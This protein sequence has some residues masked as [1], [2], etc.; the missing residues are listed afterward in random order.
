MLLVA[1][2]ELMEADMVVG[3][4][5]D[6]AGMGIAAVADTH[7]QGSELYSLNTVACTASLVG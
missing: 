2:T 7:H 4:T 1:A 3:C 6:T 5:L